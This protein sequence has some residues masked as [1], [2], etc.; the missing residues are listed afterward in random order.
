MLAA[1]GAVIMKTN[2]D[3]PMP[4]GGVGPKMGLTLLPFLAAAIWLRIS[5]PQVCEIPLLP[6]T[7]RLG[8]GALLLAV[9]VSFWAWSAIYF[10][11]HFPAGEL[12]TAGPFSWCRNPIYASFIV[13]LL[14]AAALLADAWPLFV[15]DAV[16]YVVFR[17]LIGAED[18]MLAER[19]GAAYERY[20]SEVPET[21]PTPPRLR[22]AG[23]P[24]V[25]N[26]C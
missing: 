23:R 15:V 22:A 21:V 7:V 19:F 5:W 12:L 25:R 14:P 3:R 18:R 11:R 20:R 2:V 10:V 16:L 24:H 17:A 8:L 1:N 6:A 4:W 26:S 9:G 13:C